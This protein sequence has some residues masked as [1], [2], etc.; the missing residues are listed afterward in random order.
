LPLAQKG[1][2]RRATF[3][4]VAPASPTARNVATREASRGQGQTISPDII[5]EDRYRYDYISGG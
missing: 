4:H 1:R 5:V 2:D 3:A